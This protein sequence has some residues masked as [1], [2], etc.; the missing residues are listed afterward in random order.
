MQE[1]TPEICKKSAIGSTKTLK[2][3]RDGSSY[4][5]QKLSDGNCWMAQ[6][7]AL[8][9]NNATNFSENS[10][11]SATWK[12]STTPTAANVNLTNWSVSNTINAYSKAPSKIHSSYPGDG[13]GYQTSYGTYYS[14]C[15]AT[16]ESCKSALTDK[17]VATASICPKGWQMPTPSDWTNI[18]NNGASVVK[19]NNVNYMSIDGS[20][21]PMAGYVAYNSGLTNPGADGVYWTRIASSDSNAYVLLFNTN[22]EVQTLH[23]SGKGLGHN[24]RCVAYSN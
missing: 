20:N 5:V 7:L 19:I 11:V 17:A 6:N 3:I 1:M 13:K 16:A 22:S 10:D 2:D 14:W 9:L 24:V 18:M 23:T 21:W 4:S 8:D 15:A 12:W